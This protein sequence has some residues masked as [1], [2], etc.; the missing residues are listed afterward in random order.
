[1]SSKGRVVV[2]GQ[3]FRSPFG[4]MIWQVLHYLL[5]LRDL[6]YDVWYVEDSDEYFFHPETYNPVWEIEQNV[7]RAVRYLRAFG[8]EDRWFVRAPTRFDVCYGLPNYDDLKALYASTD[9]AINLCGS[10][11]PREEHRA[12][13]NLIYLETDPVRKQVEVAK[14][15]EHAI[16][17]LDSY[18]HLCTYGVNIGRDAC[19]IPLERYR[20]V[21]TVPPVVTSLWATADAPSRPAFT[22]VANWKHGGKDVEWNSH[23]W[24]WSKHWEFMKF[25]GLPDK[26]TPAMELAIGAIDDTDRQMLRDHGWGLSASGRLA[27]PY[28]Y[29]DFIQASYG[30]FTAAKEQYVAPRSG[31]FSDRSVCYLAAGRPVV[32]QGTGFEDWIDTGNGLFGY[33]DVD[34]AAEAIAAIAADYQHHSAAATG[35]AREYFEART[36]LQRLL[37]DLGLQ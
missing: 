37:T 20:W 36:V 19:L 26:V 34:G 21:P 13:A 9:I 35:L 4:G 30:E 8:F 29:R 7:E 11:E 28:K 15:E 22:S 14:G 17:E 5:P 3:M 31:W 6:G 1:M 32:T 18:D 16:A 27:D 12:C 33:D 24:R 25:V 23:R 10:Q 2:W